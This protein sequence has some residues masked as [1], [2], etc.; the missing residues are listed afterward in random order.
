MKLF[1]WDNVTALANYAAGNIIVMAESVELARALAL[2]DFIAYAKG[3]DTS[4]WNYYFA[5]DGKVDE[6]Y[7]ESWTATLALLDEDLKA[8]PEIVSGAIIIR[9]SE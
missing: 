1:H 9:G 4:R 7:A 3:D 8:E 6:D 2:R 5:P